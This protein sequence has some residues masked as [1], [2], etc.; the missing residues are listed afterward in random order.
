MD[1]E[2]T[3]QLSELLDYSAKGNFE[4]TG[5]ITFAPP[6][7]DN[8]D[9]VTDFEQ[10]VMGAMVAAGKGQTQNIKEEDLP[11]GK[12]PDPTP[13]EVRM[14]LFVG[15]EISVKEIIRIFKKLAL[16]TATLDGVTPITETLFSK[17]DRKDFMSMLCGYTSFFILPSLLRGE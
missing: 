5:E 8:L 9:E 10:I 14:M 16:K 6:S 2:Y 11:T 13:D 3:Y 15:Q 7:M 4:K 17:M 1:K 12:M